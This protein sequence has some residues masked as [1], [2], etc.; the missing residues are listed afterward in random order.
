MPEPFQAVGLWYDDFSQTS[1]QEVADLLAAAVHLH[2]HASQAR[3][4]ANEPGM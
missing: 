2:D 3:A 4:S 1:D